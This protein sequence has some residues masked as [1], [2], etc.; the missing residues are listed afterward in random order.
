MDDIPIP[1]PYTSPAF[2]GFCLPLSKSFKGV[3]FLSSPRQEGG[4]GKGISQP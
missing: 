1:I 4:G 2:L 3:S